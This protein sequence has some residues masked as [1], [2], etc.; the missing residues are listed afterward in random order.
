MPRF[1][2]IYESENGDL[3][4]EFEVVEGATTEQV[5]EAFSHFLVLVGQAYDDESIN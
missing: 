2:F 3:I 5:I 4:K 1:K